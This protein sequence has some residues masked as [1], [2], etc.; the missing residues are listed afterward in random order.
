MVVPLAW[1]MLIA[2]AVMALLT[3]VTARA[4]DPPRWDPPAGISWQWQLSGNLKLGL[5]VDAYDVDYQETTAEQVAAIHG[6]GAKAVCYLSAG[7][8]E[9]FRPDRDQF[10][11][12]AIGKKLDGWPKERW[13]DVTDAEVKSIMQ[14]RLDICQD[15]GFDAVEFDNVDG[16]QQNTGFHLTAQ[17]QL[18]YNELLAAEAHARGMAAALKND[19]DQAAALEP[20]FDL[21][22]VEQCFQYDECDAFVPFIAAGKPVLET[23]YKL[24]RSQFCP[25]ALGL[26]FSSLK[27]HLELDAFRKA[28]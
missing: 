11:A 13:L 18:D 9:K 14:A 17:N 4:A 15:K 26:G 20:A 22:V 19:P 21:A 5:G 28:C 16:F 8:W 10:P 12:E 3:P 25:E 7:S 2:L 6:E 23:E 24:G 1:R 27:K